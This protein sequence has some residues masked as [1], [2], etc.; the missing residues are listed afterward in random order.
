MTS[1]RPTNQNQPDL[2]CHEERCA[3][4][5]AELQPEA[6]LELGALALVVDLVDP[7]LLDRHR[8]ADQRIVRQVDGPHAAAAEDSLDL[9]A[10]ESL[11]FA[12][13]EGS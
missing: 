6:L 5:G 8:A 13:G 2:I 1:N 10:S 4:S 11:G 7:D 9:E 3:S 12:Q